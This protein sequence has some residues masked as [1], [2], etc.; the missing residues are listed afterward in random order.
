[1]LKKWKHLLILFPFIGLSCSYQE[2]GKNCVTSIVTKGSLELKEEMGGYIE[3]INADGKTSTKCTAKFQPVIENG[4]FILRAYTA[5]HC[6]LAEKFSSLRAHL[7]INTKEI[8]PKYV[9][10]EVE[11]STLNHINKYFD[12]ILDELKQAYT[13]EMLYT[14]SFSILN[15]MAY[16]VLGKSRMNPFLVLIEDLYSSGTITSKKMNLYPMGFKSLPNYFSDNLKVSAAGEYYSRMLDAF[17]SLL[18]Q[19]NQTFYFL[20][21]VSEKI[22]A[23]NETSC[24]YASDL[25]VMQLALLNKNEEKFIRKFGKYKSQNFA[26][27]QF[28]LS[29]NRRLSLI[30][31]LAKSL[32][33]ERHSL[34]KYPDRYK[35]EKFNSVSEEISS[36]DNLLAESKLILNSLNSSNNVDQD[37]SKPLDFTG[38]LQ[39]KEDYIYFWQ[40][41]VDTDQNLIDNLIL[42]TNIVQKDL[43]EEMIIS[44]FNSTPFSELITEN[45]PAIITPNGIIFRGQE[46]I[47]F[48]SSD[49]GSIIT[50]KKYGPILALMNVDNKDV[51]NQGVVQNNP[52][53]A[54]YIKQI[55]D[56]PENKKVPDE[57]DKKTKPDQKVVNYPPTSEPQNPA[58]GGGDSPEPKSP[59][60]PIANQKVDQVNPADTTKPDERPEDPATNG[61]SSQAV[62][63]QNTQPIVG[64]EDRLQD[65]PDILDDEY[66]RDNYVDPTASNCM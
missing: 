40:N 29:Q 49:S 57:T 52:S 33:M 11:D 20:G 31:I 48:E 22:V 26:S 24:F 16:D 28:D 42:E 12:R 59:S 56:P 34:S 66:S 47:I 51:S 6:F 44:G 1:M 43:E 39:A 3:S 2:P 10:V 32:Q 25:E 60:E 9:S 15:F 46:K 27:T 53:L 50:H 19:N 7:N 4:K 62:I 30:S 64:T 41:I 36:I 35:K 54:D 58:I 18:C 38:S 55:E 65:P 63:Q 13:P 45:L 5:R 23:G 61:E 8:N 37:L 14:P 17:D 21:T